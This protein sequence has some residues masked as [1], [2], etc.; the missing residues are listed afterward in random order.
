MDRI[1]NAYAC[2]GS[3]DA[4]PMNDVMPTNVW[5][6]YFFM[7]VCFLE[8]TAPKGGPVNLLN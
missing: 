6:M 3:M 4:A 1:R 8:W 7:V 2:A 5:G